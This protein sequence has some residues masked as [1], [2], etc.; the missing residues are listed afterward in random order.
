MERIELVK[1][2]LLERRT[3]ARSIRK[4]LECEREYLPGHSLA[5]QE[6]HFISAIGDSGATGTE[7]ANQLKTSLSAVSQIASRLE[8]KGYITRSKAH[9][10][11]RQTLFFL[12]DL[13]IALKKAHDAFD[14][15]TYEKISQRLSI[16][17]EE[18]LLYLIEYEKRAA[19]MYGI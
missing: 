13:G 10:D 4:V 2:L 9:G 18:E 14:S 16:Y 6:A 8:K 3:A 5:M 11:K 19:K 12:T 17:S 7:V 1:T 15:V